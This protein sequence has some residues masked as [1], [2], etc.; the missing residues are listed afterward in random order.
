[1][2]V[3][4]KLT[5]IV[6]SLCLVLSFLVGILARNGFWDVLLRAVVFAVLGGGLAIALRWAAFRFLPELAEAPG[7]AENAVQDLGRT[8]DIVVEDSQ[9]EA[10]AA[11]GADAVAPPPR[12]LRHPDAVVSPSAEQGDDEF[13]QEVEELRSQEIIPGEAEAEAATYEPVRAPSILEDVDVLPDL[14]GFRTLR[15]LVLLRHVGAGLAQEGESPSFSRK[16]TRGAGLSADDPST[17]AQR[18]VRTVEGKKG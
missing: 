2:G 8:V 9:G 10:A 3:N 4:W 14:D 5:A 18:F 7:G 6:A 13:A 11:G 1:V 15:S 12:A 17:L 16:A